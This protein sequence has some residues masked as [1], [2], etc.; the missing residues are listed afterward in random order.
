MERYGNTH[1]ILIRDGFGVTDLMD[2]QLKH[3][4]FKS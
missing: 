4:P 3:R 2:I 1:W